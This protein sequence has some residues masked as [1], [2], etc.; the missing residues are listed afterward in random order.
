[1]FKK[2]F[3]MLIFSAT[4]IYI[5]SLWD[6]GF[7]LPES[8][9]GF[10]KV[11][12]VF[13]VVYYLIVPISKIILLPLNLITLGLVSFL[14][15]VLLLHFASSNFSLLTI[16]PWTFPGFIWGGITVNKIYLSYFWNLVLSSVA[17][18]S[19][20]NILEKCL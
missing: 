8:L 7:L 5:T 16:K 6:K 13:A 19:I 20:I 12:A 10:L 14:V 11:T 18:S 9:I 3:R 2:I 1:M 15:Y 4:A 17:L